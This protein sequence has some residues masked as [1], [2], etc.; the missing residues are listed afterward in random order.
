MTIIYIDENFAPQ[1]A[2]SLDLIQSH[3]N[4]KEK[5]QY[6][7]MS[8]QKR[9]GRG[10]QDE[11]WIPIAGKEN[12]VV[13]TQDLRIQTTRHQRD[14]YK[15][16]GLGVFFFKAPSKSGFSFWEMTT[17][18][19]NRWPEIKSLSS[20]TDRPFAFRCTSKQAHFELLD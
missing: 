9:F 18:L 2:E 16:F 7:V 13:I 1:L 17:Q 12:S 11:D 8:I 14:L 20:K 3:L 10:V 6:K 4:L 5:H 15:D 19:I